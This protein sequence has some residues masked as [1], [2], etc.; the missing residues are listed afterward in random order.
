KRLGAVSIS[1]QDSEAGKENVELCIDAGT[2]GNVTRYINHSCQSNLFVQCVLSA[3]HDITRARV[4]LFAADNIQSL[5]KRLGAVPISMQYS[6]AGKENVE[7]CIDAGT[8]G[9]VTRYINHSCHS[10]T[11]DLICC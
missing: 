7:L 10:G 4:I 5:K 9:N 2:I 1:M 11:G 6:E 8:I 3:H